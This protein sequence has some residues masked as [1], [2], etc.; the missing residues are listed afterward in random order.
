M[1]TTCKRS[2]IIAL[3]TSTIIITAC[4][5]LSQE[6]S[7]TSADKTPSDNQGESDRVTRKLAHRETLTFS[8]KDAAD[9]INLL[10][11]AGLK[12]DGEKEPVVA[13]KVS[14]SSI[15]PSYTNK[16]ANCEFEAENR[17]FTLHDST[18]EGIFKLIGNYHKGTVRNLRA[19]YIIYRDVFQLSCQTV[20]S[21]DKS[22]EAACTMQINSGFPY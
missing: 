18:S 6:T 14:C 21:G 11:T 19:G 8:S 13:D 2:W 9:M 22:G 1:K 10:H 16:N 15:H 5:G 3:I 17:K 20:T 4:G 12:K 7:R